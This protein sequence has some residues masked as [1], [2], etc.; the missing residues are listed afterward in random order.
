MGYFV[1]LDPIYLLFQ[2]KFT[3]HLRH[4]IQLAAFDVCMIDTVTSSTISVPEQL[5]IP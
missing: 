5:K 4:Q 2:S 3:G 1:V